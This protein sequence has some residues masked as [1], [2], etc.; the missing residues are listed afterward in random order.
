MAEIPGVDVDRLHLN[1]RAISVYVFTFGD[2]TH[3]TR[4]QNI[5]LR[6]STLGQNVSVLIPG[7][8]RNSN[9]SVPMA[10]PTPV[11][12]AL[13]SAE[14]PRRRCSLVDILI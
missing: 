9:C 10:V 4:E 2:Q 12:F 3:R 5:F 7:A 6:C 14:A 1:H 13:R 11:G 8:R